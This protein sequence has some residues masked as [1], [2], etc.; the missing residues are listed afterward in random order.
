MAK[1]IRLKQIPVAVM[2][3]LQELADIRGYSLEEA[4]QDCVN[5][6]LGINQRLEKGCELLCKEPDGTINRLVFT[7]MFK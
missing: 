5:T 7:H 4:L 2:Y 6:E 3:G 1:E